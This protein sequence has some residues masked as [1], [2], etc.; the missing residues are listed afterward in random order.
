[1]FRRKSELYNGE[2]RMAFMALSPFYLLFLSFGLF[3]IGYSIYIA[4]FDWDLLGEHTFTGIKNFQNLLA[5]ERFWMAFRNTISIWLLSSVPQLIAALGL[6]TILNKNGLKFSGFWRASVLLPNITSTVAVAVVF[7]SIF[8]R[9]FGMVNYFLSWFGIEKIDWT[10]QAWSSHTEIAIMVMWRW[11]GYNALIFLASMQSI[12][13]ELYEAAEL[14][15]ATTWQ[16]FKYVTLPGI[17]NTII[18]IVTVSTIG[19]LQIFGEPL[20]VGGGNLSGGDARQFS[21]L[22]LFLYEQAFLE[23]KFGYAAAIGIAILF[24]VIIFAL[25]NSWITSKI[26]KDD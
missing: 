17:R 15:G 12:S 3:P 23:F 24:I 19:G 13:K 26:A 7:S 2:G 10:S 20:I 5:D 21:T 1:M 8:G 9:D 16:Q 18:F 22:S 25:V 4:F 6:A 14:D 11:T